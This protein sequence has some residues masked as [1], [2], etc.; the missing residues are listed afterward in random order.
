MSGRALDRGLTAMGPRLSPEHVSVQR[1]IESLVDAG[2]AL[3]EAAKCLE[4]AADGTS[5]PQPGHRN[6]PPAERLTLRQ[7]GAIRGLSRRQGLSETALQSLIAEVSSSARDVSE[8]GKAEASALLD[9][10]NRGNADR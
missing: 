6:L 4:D 3:L 10:L 7:L 1:A 8:L 5:R 2:S 9:R